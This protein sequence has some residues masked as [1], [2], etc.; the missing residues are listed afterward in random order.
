MTDTATTTQPAKRAQMQ[1]RP[2]RPHVRKARQPSGTKS[3]T[4]NAEADDDS[5]LTHEQRQQ[6]EAEAQ[7]DLLAIERASLRGDCR[8][9]RRKYRR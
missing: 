8:R 7:A 6:R 2:D 4:A 3:T 5:A 9:S 1:R